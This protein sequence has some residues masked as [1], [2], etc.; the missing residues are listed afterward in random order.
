MDY[1]DGRGRTVIIVGVGYP[2]L[3]DRMNAVESAYDHVFE[4]GAGWD[5]AIQI[6]TIRKIRQ[7]MGRVV[8]SPDDYGVRILLDGRFLTD[9]KKRYGKFSVFNVFPEDER[10]E[11]VDVEPA[12]VKYSL[13]NF[14]MDNS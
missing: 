8:R 13:M 7:A 10:A 9:S 2:A 1:R 14:F 12:K 4:Y 3:N 6:P 5:Y 11:F